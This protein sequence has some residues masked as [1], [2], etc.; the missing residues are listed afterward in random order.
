MRGPAGELGRYLEV[1]GL[2]CPGRHG[3]ASE[4]RAA[5]TWSGRHG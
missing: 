1:L 2:E 4:A 3:V 5:K